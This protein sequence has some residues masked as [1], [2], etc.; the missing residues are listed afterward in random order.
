MSHDEWTAARRWPPLAAGALACATS[1]ADGSVAMQVP[2]HA[3]I[4][5]R[6][7][8]ANH[9][10]AFMTW[11]TGGDDIDAGTFSLLNTQF[12][13]A[14]VE[15]A[16]AT[17]W[18]ETGAITANIY[19]DLVLRKVRVAGATVSIAP[20]GGGLAYVSDARLPDPAL[21]ASTLG[22]PAVFVDLAESAS[23]DDV[24]VTISHPTRDCRGG[25]G[26]PTDDPRALRTRVRAGALVN[27]TFV[28]PP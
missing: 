5:L 4:Q 15:L 22:G 11:A 2:A 1:A 6:C 20:A 13:D 9:G 21:D 27:F 16:G 18:P 14:F 26:W 3:E 24:V 23:G 17:T 8:G 7:E 12:Q 10:P 19:E 28:C 25:F